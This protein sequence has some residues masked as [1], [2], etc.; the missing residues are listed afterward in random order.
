MSICS[1]AA[2]F[3]VNYTSVNEFSSSVLQ[4]WRENDDDQISA[5]SEAAR[6][7]FAISPNSA[8]CE[9]VLALVKTMFGE[10]QLSALADYIKAALMLRVNDRAVG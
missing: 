10:Q 8:S 1:S 9:R 5:W 3:T 7:V 2:N 6:I 4:W